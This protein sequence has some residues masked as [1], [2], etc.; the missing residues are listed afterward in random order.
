MLFNLVVSPGALL[1]CL[2]AFA[3]AMLASLAFLV[4]GWVVASLLFRPWAFGLCPYL[5]I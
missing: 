5:I 4:A 1:G 2:P 3:F